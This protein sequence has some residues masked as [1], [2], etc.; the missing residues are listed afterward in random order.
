MY[1]SFQWVSARARLHRDINIPEFDD[2]ERGE[3]VA[4]LRGVHAADKADLVR[5][6]AK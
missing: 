6:A 2:T 3:E 5:Y 1:F 4:V